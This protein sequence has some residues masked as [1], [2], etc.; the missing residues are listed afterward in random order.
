MLLASINSLLGDMETKGNDYRKHYEKYSYL[1]STDLNEMFQEFLKDA[2]VQ[3]EAVEGT[4]ADD[5]EAKKGDKA[6]DA[7]EEDDGEE[8]A[9]DLVKFDKKIRE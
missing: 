7:D 5:P 8:A 9:L 4:D 1:W 6:D 3:K 2:V